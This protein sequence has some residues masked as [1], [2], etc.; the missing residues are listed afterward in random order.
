[1]SLKK[2]YI[3]GGELCWL[4]FHTKTGHPSGQ[5]GDYAYQQCYAKNRSEKIEDGETYVKVR[6]LDVVSK[7]GKLTFNLKTVCKDGTEI[8]ETQCDDYN[9]LT[10]IKE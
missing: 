10:L 4:H 1:M 5:S 6:I 2:E 7:Y 3:E 8:Y 9:R